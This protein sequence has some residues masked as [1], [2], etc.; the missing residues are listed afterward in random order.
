MYT[1]KGNVYPEAG[2]Y[3]I[4]NGYKGF[5]APLSAAPF[6]EV[7]LDTTSITVTTE[8]VEFDRIKWKNPGIGSYT[9]AKKFIIS[10]RYSND[11]Q[12]AIMLN[13]D[14]SEEDALAYEKMQEWRAWASTMAHKI[15]EIIN[16]K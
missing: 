8:S 1:I 9:D 15:I 2:Y 7:E 4:G 3:L 6:Q 11:D 10:K 12:I 16:T 13:K 5:I 14:D